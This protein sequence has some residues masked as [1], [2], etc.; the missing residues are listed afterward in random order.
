MW[1]ESVGVNR[2]VAAAIM[3]VFALLT[4]ACFGQGTVDQQNNPAWTRGAVNIAP[5]NKVSQTFVPSLPWLISVEVALMTGNAGRGGDQITLTVLGAGDVKLASAALPLSEGFDGFLRFNLPGG[6]IS[7]TPGQPITIMLQDTG[8]IVFWWKYNNRNP[9]TSGKAYFYG[10]AFQDNDFLFRTYGTNKPI[11]SYS[12]APNWVNWASISGDGGM[13][14]TGSFR[15]NTT[16]TYGVYCLDKT[17]TL[18]WMDSLASAF[19]G[20]FW[21]AISRNGAYGATGGWGTNYKG[22]V[23]AYNIA[24]G[25][26]LL[27]DATEKRVNVVALSNDGSWFIAADGGKNSQHST[28]RLYR[29]QGSGSALSYTLSSQYDS[30]SNNIGTASI[31][32]DG[33]WIVMGASHGS[34]SLFANVNGQLTLKNTWPSGALYVEFVDISA[35]GSAFGA[36]FPD[37]RIAVFDLQKFATTGNPPWTAQINGSQPSRLH[38]CGGDNVYGIRVSSNGTQV[39]AASNCYPDSAGGWIDMFKNPSKTGANNPPPEWS[40]FTKRPPN[41]GLSMDGAMKYVA[42][43]DGHPVGT[44]GDFYLLDATTGREIWN[45]QSGDM[46]W[47]ISLSYDGKY[48][49]GGS[50]DGKVYF[51]KNY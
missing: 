6:G 34:V 21:T 10:S 25:Q 48:I 36:S 26:R 45:Y 35:D 18:K 13:V 43:A 9:Y 2:R 39:V 42:V 14:L 49:V 30:G 41:P 50:D 37:G 15:M 1:F 29:L 40:Y 27:D 32:Q 33:A 44:Q 28:L 46:N 51:W 4:G 3:I 38:S 20:V 17:G 19:E 47:P 22:F 8:K 11:W 7:V 23:R 12:V 31:S 24:T 5:V 16:T